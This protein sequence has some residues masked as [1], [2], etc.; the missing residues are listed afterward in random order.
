MNKTLRPL[1]GLA[2]V[3]FASHAAAQITFYEGDGFRGRTF[4]AQQVSNFER[5]GFNDRASSVVVERGR[6]EVCENAR[7]EGH[8]VVLHRGSYDSLRAWASTTGS[9]R[10]ARSTR[11][12]YDNERRSR[13]PRRVRIPPPPERALIEVPVTSVRAV[14]GPPEQRCWV[15]QQQVGDRAARPQRAGRRSSAACSAASSATRSAAARAR[16]SRRSAARSAARRSAPT[17][18][19][20]ATS[21]RAR[22]CAAA[23]TSPSSTP[24]YWDVT[25][26][27]RGVE[28]RV[29]MTTPARA[30]DRRQRPTASRA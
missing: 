28:H 13:S 24:Q 21:S 2:A 19:A 27:F 22:T 8:C 16:P 17:S 14:V 18:T 23:K 26:N 1:L 3:A 30:D 7:F 11:E 9:R 6:W 12:H 20:S 5:A 25:Y 10:C 4:A 15:E 29:Q